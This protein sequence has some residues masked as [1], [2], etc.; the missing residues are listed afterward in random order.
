MIAFAMA[1]EAGS[2]IGCGRRCLA[3][4][5]RLDPLPSQGPTPSSD[6]NAL[7]ITQRH[8]AVFQV[9]VV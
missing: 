7:T 5:R 9:E 2:P 3:M 1:A 6:P 8:A 4:P